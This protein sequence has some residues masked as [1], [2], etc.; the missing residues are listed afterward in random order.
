M[1]DFDDITYCLNADC[2]YKD[3]ERNAERLKGQHGIASF[4]NFGGVCRKYLYYL[5]EVKSEDLYLGGD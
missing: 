1:K 4:A 2:P 5:I 3:C